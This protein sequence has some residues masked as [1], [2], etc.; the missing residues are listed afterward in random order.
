MKNKSLLKI[1]FYIIMVF[2][3]L[4]C[5][6][7]ASKTPV[8]PQPTAGEVPIL[9]PTKTFVVPKVVISTPT[10]P[11][12]LEA[13]P[14][15]MLFVPTSSTER[16]GVG[17]GEETKTALATAGITEPFFG[18][19]TPTVIFGGTESPGF[20]SSTAQPFLTGTPANATTRPTISPIP[21]IKNVTGCPDIYIVGI[22]Q[23]STLTVR[24][25]KL[26]ENKAYSVLLN[27]IKV[28]TF[29]TGVISSINATYSIPPSLKGTSP[30]N[31]RILYSN[32]SFCQFFF[33]NVTT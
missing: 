15:M 21:I 22:V 3:I 11:L 16:A 9:A 5:T 23:D 4:G 24:L 28:G 30:I 2:G 33:Y 13:T 20:P 19:T 1:I 32:G 25:D 14:T 17:V 6:R 26:P 7:A 8:V 31:V 18:E 29:D 27:G 12:K 10:T